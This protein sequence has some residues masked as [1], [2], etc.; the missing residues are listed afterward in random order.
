MVHVQTRMYQEIF[1]YSHGCRPEN[2]CYISLQIRKLISVD[3]DYQRMTLKTEN[4]TNIKT[5]SGHEDSSGTP[6]LRSWN[7]LKKK[8]R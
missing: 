6:Y 3:E 7:N 8:N 5:L 4:L 2:H 1:R